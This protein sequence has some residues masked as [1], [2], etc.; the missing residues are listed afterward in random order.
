MAIEF[1]NLIK[2]T[3]HATEADESFM[4]MR[5]PLFLFQQELFTLLGIN[6][7]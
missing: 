6:S 7:K 5:E 4:A 3:T 1:S 2:T